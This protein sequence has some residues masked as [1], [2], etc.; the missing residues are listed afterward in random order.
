MS[1]P[2]SQTFPFPTELEAIVRTINYRPG[3]KFILSHIERDPGSEGLTLIIITNGFD[4]YHV[5]NGPTYRVQHFFPVPAATYNKQ[6][7]TR[8][9]FDCLLKVETHEACEFFRFQRP[10]LDGTGYMEDIRPYAPNH[11]PG[12]DP[13]TVRELTTDEERRTSF[14]GIVKENTD[15][16]VDEVNNPDKTITKEK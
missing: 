7:W 9:V 2:I 13:Y 11:G 12:N 16:F 4:S 6:S 8:W 5:E 10:R 1:D 3:W 14:R 15:A